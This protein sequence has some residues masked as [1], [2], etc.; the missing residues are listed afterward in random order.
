MRIRYS[1]CFR[2]PRRCTQETGNQV[3]RLQRVASIHIFEAISC[4]IRIINNHTTNNLFLW[5]ENK[6]GVVRTIRTRTLPLYENSQQRFGGDEG[7]R[8][9]VVVV[10]GQEVAVRRVRVP[11]IEVQA[12]ADVVPCGQELP[13]VLVARRVVAVD[14]EPDD[15]CVELSR[16]EK[17]KGHTLACTRS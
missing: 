4:N 12:V 16:E 17:K 8:Q 9:I 5:A 6:N 1:G 3:L 13:E 11:D 7:P 10:D 2:L 14:G 15:V